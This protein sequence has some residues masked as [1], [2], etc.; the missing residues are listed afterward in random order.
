MRGVLDVVIEMKCTSCLAALDG[1]GANTED[2]HCPN[3]GCLARQEVQY[4]T[5]IRARD[6]WWFAVKYHLPFKLNDQWYCV[7]GPTQDN[8]TLFQSIYLSGGY[9]TT[10]N[11]YIPSFTWISQQT[12]LF[13]VPYMALPVN[14]DF[15]GEWQKLQN[16]FK[17]ILILR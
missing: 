6:N 17:D 4:Y 10:T 11:R 13:K 5:H 2:Y 1:R 8:E 14:Q 3:S 7:V 9:W 15:W 12:E 16:L